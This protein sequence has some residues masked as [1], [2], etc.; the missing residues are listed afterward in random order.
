V[1]S[2][3]APRL[4]ESL[5]R[6]KTERFTKILKA[7][8]ENLPRGD[9]NLDEHAT[10][11][12]FVGAGK[13]QISVLGSQENDSEIV[14]N[15]GVFFT[16]VTPSYCCGDEEPMTHDAYIELRIAIDKSNAALRVMPFPAS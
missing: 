14:V 1:E 12:S 15:I 2:K 3:R 10:P 13:I 4:I 6:W 8:L 16:E 7:E 11:G 9:L 5:N